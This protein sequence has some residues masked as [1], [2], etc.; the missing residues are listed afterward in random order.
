MKH[1]KQLYKELTE[2]EKKVIRKYLDKEVYNELS[3]G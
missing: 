3:N 1:L 2:A